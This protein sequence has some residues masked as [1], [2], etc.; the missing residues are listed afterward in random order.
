MASIESSAFEGCSGLTTIYSEIENP[1]AIGD[2]VFYCSSK[3]IYTTATL[4]VPPGEKS[5]YQNTAGW[6]KFTNIVEAELIGYEFETNGIRY[7]IG[8]NNT[9]SVIEKNEKYFGDVVIP[10]SVDYKGN[11]YKVT[12]IRYTAFY[13]C[14]GL[15]SIIIPNGITLIPHFT[16]AGCGS[17]TSVTIP[18]SLKRIGENAFTE[19]YNLNAVYISDLEAWLNID[20]E[21][22]ENTISGGYPISSSPLYYANHLY[23][24][25]KEITE[26]EIP[27]T[28]STIKNF[29]FCNWRSLT[30]I[31]IPNSVTSI[32]YFSFY[33]CSG[34]TSVNIPNSVTSIGWHAFQNCTGLT[35]IVSEIENPFEIDEDVFYSSD[36]DIYSTATLI[37]PF[38]KKTAYENTA[39]WKKF[40]NIV[41]KSPG[42]CYNFIEKGKIA[43][44]IQNPIGK[45]TGAIKIPTKVLYEGEEYSVVK[46]ADNAF[47][48]CSN[49]TSVEIPN[50]VTSI[51]NSAFDH[52]SNLS[53]I[54]IPNSVMS[55]GVTA[56]NSCSNLTSVTIPNNLTLLGIQAFSNCSSLISVTIPNSL[57]S[58]SFGLFGGCSSLTSVEIPNSVSSIDSYAF[59]NC[60]G[61]TTIT[62]CD[63]SQTTAN[64]ECIVPNGCYVIW[65]RN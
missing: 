54:S 55:I 3:N 45:Y 35:T 50:S 26:L 1:F 20:I 62:N 53:L 8:E 64:K 19:C 58:I 47:Y 7:K 23:L 32:N 41:E 36:V 63:S 31:S 44:V 17:L 27:N 51:G 9:V 40:T 37:V 10:E 12:S 5:A 46:I 48:G 59:S 49:L 13:C 30:S 25:G 65:Y 42:L 60:T 24:N 29:T 4:I 43:E 39:G 28:I 56:F 15:T 11:T 61:L 57:T 21:E 52:C 22:G 16:F 38:G 18:K 34:L 6:N 2:F 33:K 14:N